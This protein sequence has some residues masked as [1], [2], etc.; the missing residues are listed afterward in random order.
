M[1]LKNKHIL[2]GVTGGIAAYKAAELTRAL[3]A[4][5]ADV[6]VMM[7]P[8]AR[9]FIGEAS[10]RALSGHAVACDW[11]DS[12]SDGK[13]GASGGDGMP[14]IRLARW[15]DVIVIAPLSANTLAKLAHGA[16][17]NLPTAVCLSDTPLAVVPAMNREMWEHAAVQDN[18]KTLRAR[19]VRVWGPASGEQACGEVG[20][21]RM[22]EPENIVSALRASFSN[23]RRPAQSSFPLHIMITAGPTYEAIDEV[24]YIGNRSSG[25]MGF[26]LA[27]AAASVADT[28]LIAGPVTQPTPPGVLRTDVVCAEEMRL[29]VMEHIAETDIFISCAAV[30]DY[31][32][33]VV[34]TGKLKKENTGELRLKLE[35]TPDILLEA[36]TGEKRP[37][38]VG[39]A[40]ETGNIEANAKAKLLAKNLD[41]VVA[42]LVGAAAEYG[43][44]SDDN[45]VSVYWRSG[46]ENM[47]PLPKTVLAGRLIDL[48]VR[49]YSAATRTRRESA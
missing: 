42:N 15:A 35:R 29:A 8:D 47:G 36:A 26:A 11:S 23:T 12:S 43:F 17:D 40:A 6:R 19:G 44:D 45:R 41:M 13:D 27:M 31:R 21:G 16:A 10:L 28:T 48:I 46:G 34:Q 1:S 37:F 2:L 14:H 25:K 20:V 3:R 24:R 9:R 5:G 22:L 32:C 38:C 49:R 7:T 4:E 39:F 30:A 33:A 18:I